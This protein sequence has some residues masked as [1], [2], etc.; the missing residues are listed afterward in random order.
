M[1]AIA[2]TSVVALGVIGLGALGTVVYVVRRVSPWP[3]PPAPPGQSQGTTRAAG[4]Q[5]KAPPVTEP[6]TANGSVPSGST[7]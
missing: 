6:A 1:N 5:D 7:V 2:E 4:G 3:K